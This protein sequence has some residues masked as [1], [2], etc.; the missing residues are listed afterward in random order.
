[1]LLRLAASSLAMAILLTACAAD[2]ACSSPVV[3][4]IDYSHSSEERVLECIA[5]I[6]ASLERCNESLCTAALDS[7]WQLGH[8]MVAHDF[9][10]PGLEP[11]RA[12]P[13]FAAWAAMTRGHLHKT[14]GPLMGGLLQHP[15]PKVVQQAL[16]SAGA[17]GWDAPEYL[18]LAVDSL[19][20][21]S[22]AWRGAAKGYLRS[23]GAAGTTAL[24]DLLPTA[25]PVIRARIFEALSLT[26]TFET[27]PVDRA[28]ELS[29]T[30]ITAIWDA[31][32]RLAE[33]ASFA[34]TKR[35]FSPERIAPA[36]VRGVREGA[37][38]VAA[39]CALALEHLPQ[40]PADQQG[41]LVEFLHFPDGDVSRS[42]VHILARYPDTDSLLIAALDSPYHHTRGAA[43]EAL[44]AR[45]QDG[46][47]LVPFLEMGLNHELLGEVTAICE[48]RGAAVAAIFSA[49]EAVAAS[50]QYSNVRAA[51]IPA[52]AA[53]SSEAGPVLAIYKKYW[54]IAESDERYVML[55]SLK[56]F[57][58]DAVGFLPEIQERLLDFSDTF[59]IVPALELVAKIGPAAGEISPEIAL[60]LSS[61]EAPGIQERALAALEALGSA[62]C[63][64]R[65]AL[66]RFAA[67]YPD[68]KPWRER[69]AALL[70]SL[71]CN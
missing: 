18:E 46:A 27:L 42:A 38:I 15:N 52:F 45:F 48:R 40:I 55:E 2:R 62:A 29:D 12:T 50:T 35:G 53:V 20:A 39:H 19:S 56:R 59:G 6:C 34:L 10:R 47:G 22:E 28:A 37:A 23:V 58:A 70:A 41:V 1:M 44:E 30:L 8:S 54:P 31:D 26:T 71:D 17:M 57:G 49:L 68:S 64:S 43:L 60:W 66:E 7:L 33:Q 3:E 13:E 24:M 69:T 9:F 4:I 25:D 11:W 16:S 63:P 32:A 21:E 51:V 65:D 14:V 61:V 36:L 67:L 5:S